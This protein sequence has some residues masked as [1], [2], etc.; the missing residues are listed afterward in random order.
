MS[1]RIRTIQLS[2]RDVEYLLAADFL[3]ERLVEVL[4]HKVQWQNKFK[5][6][7]QLPPSVAEEFRDYFTDHLVKVGFD[8]KYEPNSEGVQLEALTDRFFDSASEADSLHSRRVRFQ[9]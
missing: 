3:P 8:E 9:K 7:L 1:E 6:T 5:A 2:Q 4:K